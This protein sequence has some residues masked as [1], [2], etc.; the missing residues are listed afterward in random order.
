MQ[1]RIVEQHRED[2][3]GGDRR[4]NRHHAAA[5]RF[6]QAQNVRLHVFVLAGEHLAGTPHAG[7]DFVEDQQRAKLVAQLTHGRQIA[8]RREDDAAFTLNG[9]QDHRRHVIA[10]FTAFAQHGAHGVNVA[11]RHVAEARQQRHK[12]FTESGFRGRRQCAEGFTVERAAGGDKGEFP[13]RRLVR[14]GELN[15]RFD[16]FC[17]AVAEEAVFQFAGR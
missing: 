7:L 14:F 5:E 3:F 11:E 1:E 16:R 10:G 17:T 2:F 8:L 4:A 6:R 15:R 12:R 9:L 13:A